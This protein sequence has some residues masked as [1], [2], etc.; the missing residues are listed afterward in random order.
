M[1]LI[2][3]ECD[4][5]ESLQNA[6]ESLLAEAT[7]A[8]DFLESPALE[9]PTRGLKAEDDVEAGEGPGDQVGPYLLHE[10]VGEGGCGRVYRA[11]QLEPVRR[12][13]ALKILK[14]GMDTRSVIR[15]FEVERQALA[16]MDHPHIARV[17]DA[18]ASSDGRP[19]F[20][21]DFVE[22]ISITKYCNT[23][24]LSLR[25]RVGI[26]LKV[27]RAVEHAHQKGIIHRDLKPS[28][29]LIVEGDNDPVPKVIDFGVA[30]AIDSMGSDMSLTF[31]DTVVGTP[32]YLSLIH[33]SEPTRPY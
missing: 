27:C 18:G 4:G 16:V 25:A 32:V 12:V 1:A 23:G 17:L 6:V 2:R 11:E 31:H 7:E 5:D 26:M 10:Q 14:L 24:E 20:V 28:N 22:G 3:R 8:V 13:V 15:R 29:I 9:D 30:K 19:Y 21:M 33:I